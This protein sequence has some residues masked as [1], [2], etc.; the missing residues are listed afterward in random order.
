MVLFNNNELFKKYS[1]KA[2]KKLQLSIVSESMPS[3]ILF[4]DM[5]E[6]APFLY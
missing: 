2:I 4:I 5:K 6:Y 3:V 1:V